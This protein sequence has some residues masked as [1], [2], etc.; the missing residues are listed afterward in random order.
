MEERCYRSVHK[1]VLSCEIWKEINVKLTRSEQ[2]L[3]VLVLEMILDI[4][5]NCH[6]HLQEIYSL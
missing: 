2:D 3:S 5:L 4:N 1:D 6:L